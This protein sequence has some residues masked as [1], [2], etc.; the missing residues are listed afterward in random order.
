MGPSLLA[1]ADFFVGLSAELIG[2]TIR[3]ADDELH[4]ALMI[5]LVIID[6]CGEASGRECFSALIQ[7]DFDRVACQ[8]FSDF[9]TFIALHLR[10]IFDF[11]FYFMDF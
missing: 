4:R 3:A 8:Q 6:Q 2:Q 11:G 9:I 1:E 10:R 5:D 7:Y